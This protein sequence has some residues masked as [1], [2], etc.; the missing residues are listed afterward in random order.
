MKPR[1]LVVVGLLTAQ[2]LPL[3]AASVAANFMHGDFAANTGV[4]SGENTDTLNASLG[5]TSPIWNNVSVTGAGGAIPGT[6]TLAYG[7][8][9]TIGLTYHAANPWAAGSE[10]VSGS[11]ASQQVFREY[12][13]DG[14]GGASSYSATDSYGVTLQLSGLSAFVANNPGATGY[15]IS[16]LYSTDNTVTAFKIGEVR[17]GALTGA[18]AVTD[19]TLLQ[20][21]GTPTVFANGGAAPFPGAGTTGGTRGYV[22]STALSADAITVAISTSGAGRG[23][24]AGFVINSVPE[25]AS[26]SF[27]GLSLALALSRRSRK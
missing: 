24:I 23:A 7:G 17:A 15:T 12:L 8:A 9:F 18:N 2:A 1:L 26:L 20:T 22:T 21:L 25:P 16:L 27:V 14:G 5:V 19:L 6:V 10:T 11:D 13:D 4:N 3:P